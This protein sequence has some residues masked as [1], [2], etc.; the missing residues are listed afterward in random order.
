MATNAAEMQAT[1]A[2][3]LLEHILVSLGGTEEKPKSIAFIDEQIDVGEFEKAAENLNALALKA[4]YKIQDLATHMAEKVSQERV[5][6]S[7]TYLR[8]LAE[9]VLT[10]EFLRQM[11]EKELIMEPKSDST[12]HIWK[13]HFHYQSSSDNTFEI[14]VI[15]QSGKFEE[16]LVPG[17]YISLNTRKSTLKATLDA[18]EKHLL[19]DVQTENMRTLAQT[20]QVLAKHGTHYTDFEINKLQFSETMKL[21]TYVLDNKENTLAKK[22]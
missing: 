3:E 20:D 4:A 9:L 22:K 7:E 16:G 2:E 5:L 8:A 14:K 19:L 6:D 13:G 15:P 21:L 11:A 1:Q 10:S 12:Q 18:G 17:V